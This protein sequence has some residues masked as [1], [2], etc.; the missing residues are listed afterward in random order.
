MRRYKAPLGRTTRVNLLICLPA[1]LAVFVILAMDI[2]PK[3]R[4]SLTG[5]LLMVL[6]TV[7]KMA[8]SSGAFTQVLIALAVLYLPFVLYRK[9]ALA[10]VLASADERA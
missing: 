1:I 2:A 3:M 4:G 5:D 10:A 8:F 9:A 6:E 7:N